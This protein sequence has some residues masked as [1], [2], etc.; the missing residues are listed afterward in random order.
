MFDNLKNLWALKSQMTEI[1]KRLDGMIVKVESPNKVFE[2]VMSG[3]QEVREI[4]I[5]ASLA[6]LTDAQIEAELKEVFNKAARDSQAMAAQVMGG[7]AGIN[8][9]QA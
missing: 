4:K 2:M 7:L 3:S 6:N 5:M 8:P 1:K 9:P